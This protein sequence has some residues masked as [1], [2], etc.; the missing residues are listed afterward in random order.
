M[1]AALSN[2]L[3]PTATT[4]NRTAIV[5]QRTCVAGSGAYAI[6]S[7]LTNIKAANSARLDASATKTDVVKEAGVAALKIAAGVGAIFAAFKK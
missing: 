4:D 7:S 5:T 1:T 2:W 3:R 6:Y